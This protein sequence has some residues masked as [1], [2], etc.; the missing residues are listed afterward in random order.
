MV[1][2]RAGAVAAAVTQLGVTR[3]TVAE[4]VRRLES[5]LSLVLLESAPGGAA[6]PT[7]TGAGLL[8]PAENLVKLSQKLIVGNGITDTG[9][10]GVAD[11]VV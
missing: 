9:L 10:E 5:T 1:V 8:A 4:R 2:A 11:E 7:A 6:Q 3:S